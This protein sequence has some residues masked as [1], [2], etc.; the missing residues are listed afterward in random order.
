MFMGILKRKDLYKNVYKS[1][2]LHFE[3]LRENKLWY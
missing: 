2:E 1:S 3:L